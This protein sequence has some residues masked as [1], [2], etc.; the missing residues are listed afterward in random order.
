[1]SGFR[2]TGCKDRLDKEEKVK[3][4]YS[5]E[6]HQYLQNYLHC[7]ANSTDGCLKMREVLNLVLGIN[8]STLSRP[9]LKFQAQSVYQNDGTHFRLLDH[10]K[11]VYGS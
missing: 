11:D 1:M 7:L 3:L 8:V 2:G 6:L 4:L 10:R 9:C 5:I